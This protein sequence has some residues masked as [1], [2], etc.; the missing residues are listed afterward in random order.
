MRFLMWNSY[1]ILQTHFL[2][3]GAEVSHTNRCKTVRTVRH[4]NLVPKCLGAKVSER[5]TT[6]LDTLNYE[7]CKLAK[8]WLK[9][10]TAYNIFSPCTFPGVSCCIHYSHHG[11]SYSFQTYRG[12]STDETVKS[13]IC[14][15]RNR[16]DR[17][18]NVNHQ[19]D[20]WER[21]DTLNCRK[22]KRMQ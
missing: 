17:Q 12:Q 7:G 20:D 5:Q 18:D 14:Q 16:I 8:P 1:N 19:S 11:V 2:C 21:L 13:P 9:R 15:P 3:S 6:R 22:K 4:R 10:S